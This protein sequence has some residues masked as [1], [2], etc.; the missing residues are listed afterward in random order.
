VL[1]CAAAPGLPAALFEAD[2]LAGDAAGLVL[3]LHE[4]VEAAVRVLGADGPLPAARVHVFAALGPDVRDVAAL[5]RFRGVVADDEDL[6]DVGPSFALVRTPDGRV[7]A[8]FVAPGTYRFV[9]SAEA[10]G[11][12]KVLVRAWTPW[13]LEEIRRLPDVPADLATPV[14][15]AGAEKD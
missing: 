10:R 15:L 5:G 14:R 2:L 1:L 9:V 8:P 7:S 4:G 6:A 13:A 3:P 11:T 12:A